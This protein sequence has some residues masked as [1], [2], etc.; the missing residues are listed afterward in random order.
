MYVLRSYICCS[1][2]ECWRRL[3]TLT[4]EVHL[5]LFPVV[6][7]NNHDTRCEPH[8]KPSI[9][10]PQQRNTKQDMPHTNTHVGKAPFRTRHV[11]TPPRM[12]H[13]RRGTYT[14]RRNTRTL[15]HPAPTDVPSRLSQICTSTKTTHLHIPFPPPFH[16][17]QQPKT[18][19]PLHPHR[20]VQQGRH[21]RKRW[22][23]PTAPSPSTANTTLWGRAAH[24]APSRRR[25]EEQP[26]RLQRPPGGSEGVLRR[27]HRRRRAGAR[28][29]RG[30][31]EGLELADLG[32]E[33]GLGGLPVAQTRSAVG[34]LVVRLLFWFVSVGI[35][36][37]V[38]CVR[39]CGG[40]CCV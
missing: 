12:Q 4:L 15:R 2:T 29:A 36:V 6:S 8:A 16:P 17:R 26:D 39:V 1:R 11:C 31:D 32:L 9:V 38:K 3:E 14:S 20:I 25:R 13:E 7:A 28:G 22:Q 23:P 5:P 37:V 10:D 40:V 18:Y 30:G 21:L 19:P 34:L 33:R 35:G 27:R 24:G